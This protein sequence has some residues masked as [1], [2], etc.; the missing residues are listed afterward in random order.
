MTPLATALTI[1]ERVKLILLSCGFIIG[2]T[3]LVTIALMAGLLADLRD[4][5]L[6]PKGW[7]VIGYWGYILRPATWLDMLHHKAR[8]VILLAL[9]APAVLL[10]L[11]LLVG[12]IRGRRTPVL[13]VILTRLTREKGSSF[14]LRV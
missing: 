8:A 3:W 10:W 11:F 5:P 2:Y 1:P 9:A 12:A 14:R 7:S 6:D 13:D 4:T